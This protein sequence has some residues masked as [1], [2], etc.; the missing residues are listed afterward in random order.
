LGNDISAGIIGLGKMGLLHASILSVMDGVKVTALCEKSTL[1][2]RFARKI[3]PETSVVEDV[4]QLAGKGLDVVFVTTPIPTHFPIIQGV[5][6]LQIARHV[7]AEKTLASNYKESGELCSLAE[8]SSGVTMVGY[9]R[10]FA[11]TFAKAGEL[12]KRGALGD[13]VSFEAHAYSSDFAGGMGGG[14]A[15]TR[16]GVL[17]DL[18]SHAIDLALWLFGDMKA[19]R[20]IDPMPSSPNAAAPLIFGAKTIGGLEGEFK[21]SWSVPGYRMPEIGISVEGDSGSLVANDDVVELTPKAG[22]PTRWYRQGLNDS[23][24]F[25]LGGPEY[26]RQ[27]EE[28]VRS[29]REG[30]SPENSFSSASKTDH[31]IDDAEGFLK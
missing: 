13:L 12:L 6:S 16:G 23:V 30:R 18:G 3:L 7:F 5:Y 21:V 25:L 17:R 11:V 15:N 28:M 9:Q 26:Y 10:R 8:H 31:I 22:P 2:S 24:P 27:D 19:E 29:L 14:K 20:S 4:A 1:I